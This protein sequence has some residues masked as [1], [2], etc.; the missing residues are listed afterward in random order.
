VA[1]FKT[2][3]NNILDGNE[4]TAKNLQ[5]SDILR[6]FRISPNAIYLQSCAS[7]NVAV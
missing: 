2:P 6:W 3:F 7:K 1:Y 5:I 4:E